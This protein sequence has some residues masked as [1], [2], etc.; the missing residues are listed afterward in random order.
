MFGWSG[1]G[2]S[3]TLREDLGALILQDAVVWE[4][5]KGIPFLPSHDKAQRFF[6]ADGYV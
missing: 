4:Q 1:T 5:C 2:I 6:I 3:G